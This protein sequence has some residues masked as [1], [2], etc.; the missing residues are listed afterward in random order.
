M[1]SR[2]DAERARLVLQELDKTTGRRFP[3]I[4]WEL[5]PGSIARLR[6]IADRVAVFHLG[7]Q[8]AACALEAESGVGIDAQG[9]LRQD[10]EPGLLEIT[11]TDEPAFI[12][13]T[14]HRPKF[15]CILLA[16]ILLFLLVMGLGTTI[17]F[18]KELMTPFFMPTR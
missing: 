16:L 18:V 10:S 12:R 5:E 13:K 15:A 7:L 11:L 17:F 9:F 2:F 6:G 4:K 1:L 8:L 14:A 3:R